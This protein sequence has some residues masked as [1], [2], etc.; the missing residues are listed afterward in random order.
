[1]ITSHMGPLHFYQLALP[2]PK[3]KPGSFDATAAS[4]GEQ[5]FAGK[6]RCAT[7]HVPPLF[8]EPGWNV[9]KPSEIG[10][11][12]FQAN[13]APD[14][15]YRTAPL[16][17]L[18]THAKGGFYHDGRFS[19]LAAVI[20]HYNQFLKLA[21][22]DAEKRD[23]VEYSEVA[24]ARFLTVCRRTLDPSALRRVGSPQRGTRRFRG[25]TVGSSF[26]GG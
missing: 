19:D 15:T 20:E 2:V 14:H 13:R 9:H 22:T 12:D 16:R 11:D 21:L 10:V 7:C 23:L 5:T 4:R 17:G 24:V 25:L 1:M 8:T 3:P 26:Q 18:M 6:A